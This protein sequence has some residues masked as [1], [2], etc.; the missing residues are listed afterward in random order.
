MAD[1]VRRLQLGQREIDISTVLGD[2]LQRLAHASS[3]T[4]QQQLQSE[5]KWADDML[6]GDGFCRCVDITAKNALTNSGRLKSVSSFRQ[7]SMPLFVLTQ[8]VLSSSART[9][10]TIPLTPLCRQTSC[11]HRVPRNLNA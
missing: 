7:H 10:L 2:N 3:Q 6:A 11:A 5:L 8:R 1:H 4:L 9:Q